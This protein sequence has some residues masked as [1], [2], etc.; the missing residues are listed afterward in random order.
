MTLPRITVVTPSLNQAAFL[1]QTILS[2]LGQD[3]PNLEYIILDGGSNDGSVEII[4]KYE[5]QLAWW[6]SEKDNGQAAAINRAFARAT[7]DILAWLNSDDTYLPGALSYIGGALDPDKAEVRFGNCTHLVEDQK[8]VRGSDVMRMH[9]EMNLALA[10][11]IIQPSAFWTRRA[12]TQTGSLDESLTFAFDWDWLLRARKQGVVLTPDDRYLAVYRMHAT[13]KSATGGQRRQRELAAIYARHAGQRYER[14]FEDCC[15]R[16]TKI[17]SIREWLGRARLSR[18]APVV[19]RAAFP[20]VFRGFPRH[21]IRDM[22]T[23]L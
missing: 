8:R 2:V 18:L 23:M 20:S 1:E 3:Y 19:L 5:Q 13:H 15:A 16:R 10:D 6:V 12:W 4:R 14:L 11:Y 17:L 9:R 7:G 21:E 22:L